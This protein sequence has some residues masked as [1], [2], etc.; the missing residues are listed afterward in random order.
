[1]SEN[2]NAVGQVNAATVS[3]RI[4]LAYSIGVLPIADAV[5]DTQ[6]DPADGEGELLALVFTSP[7]GSE[8]DIFV[9]GD[10]QRLA[11]LRGI[12]LVEIASQIPAVG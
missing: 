9:V 5:P 2:G 10:A 4:H 1:M 8:R 12:S 6:I 3:R 11:I 7:D